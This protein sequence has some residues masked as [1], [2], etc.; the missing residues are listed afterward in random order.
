MVVIRLPEIQVL[1]P[2]SDYQRA[3]TYHE[4]LQL[5]EAHKLS[6]DEKLDLLLAD[7]RE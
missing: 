3:R 5:A 2:G 6:V 7:R 4:E 1:F